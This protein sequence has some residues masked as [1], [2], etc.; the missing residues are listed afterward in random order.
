MTDKETTSTNKP[1]G[2]EEYPV[3]KSMCFSKCKQMLDNHLDVYQCYI[4]LIRPHSTLAIK[5]EKNQKNIEQ[6][7]SIAEGITNHIWTWEEFLMFKVDVARL[8]RGKEIYPYI[9]FIIYYYCCF[10]VIHLC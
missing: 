9:F 6:T 5:T 3:R 7:P 2:D 4:T 10:L 8:L 1:I